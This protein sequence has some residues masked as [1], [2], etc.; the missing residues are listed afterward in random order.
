MPIQIIT[1]SH[2]HMPSGHSGRCKHFITELPGTRKPVSADRWLQDRER[3]SRD[4]PLPSRD[5]SGYL[6]EP[7]STTHTSV[8]LG[9]R[10]SIIYFF[11]SLVS[12]FVQYT[13][14]IKLLLMSF[15]CGY[16]CVDKRRKYCQ[17]S[18]SCVGRIQLYYMYQY[19]YKGD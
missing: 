6:L 18:R 16:T 10:D 3:V 4:L 9:V 2:P 12:L 5:C 13:L 8:Q 7:S 15:S 19:I 14:I 11:F 17:K 1:T